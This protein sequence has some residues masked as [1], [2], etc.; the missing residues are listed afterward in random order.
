MD[1]YSRGRRGGPAKSVD[2]DESC[3][4]SNPSPS[5]TSHMTWGRPDALITSGWLGL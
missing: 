4:G 3:E 2:G 5:A 1:G